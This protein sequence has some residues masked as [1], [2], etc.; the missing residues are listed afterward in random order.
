MPQAGFR[1]Q[2]GTAEIAVFE[3]IFAVC[4][5]F[6]VFRENQGIVRYKMLAGASLVLLMLGIAQQKN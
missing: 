5:Y 4:L 2:H 1:Q 3:L 6:T